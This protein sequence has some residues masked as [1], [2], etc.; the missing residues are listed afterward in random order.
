MNVVWLGLPFGEDVYAARGGRHEIRTLS[1]DEDTDYRFAPDETAADVVARIGKEWP[2]DLFVCWCPELRP[3]PHAVEQ[4][5]VR[6]VAAVSDWNIYYPQLEY[7]LARYDVVLTDRLGSQC[8]ELPGAVPQYVTPLYSQRS[9]VHRN[10]DLDRDIDVLFVGNLNHAIHG[11]RG[12]CLERIAALSDQYAVAIC[13]GIYD[14]DYAR[15]LNRARIVFNHSVRREMNLRCFEALACGALLFVEEDNLEVGDWLRDRE[16][17]VLFRAENLIPLLCHYLDRP[18][19]ADRIA[20]QGHAR[21]AELAAESRLDALFE[22]AAG[23]PRGQGAAAPCLRNRGFAT[24]SEETRAFADVMQYSSSLAPSQRA[25]VTGLLAEMRGRFPNR[26]E[27]LAA[28][29]CA[30]LE[31][32]DSLSTEERK[33]A[34]REVL[35][36]FQQACSQAPESAVMWLNLAHVSRLADAPEAE[37]A[38]LERALEAPDA[39]Y[40]GL[41]IGKPTDP[42]YAQWRRALALREL[43]VEI[44]W[45]AAATRLAALH[46]DR[47]AFD[48]ARAFAQRGLGWFPDN[49]MPYRIWAVAES[50]LG[51]PELAADILERALPTT[52]FDE[53]YRTDLVRALI[54]AGRRD[55]AREVAEESRRLF[56]CCW[57]CEHI[58]REFDQMLKEL[59]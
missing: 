32:L 12:R 15:L 10:M 14:E 48:T 4:C 19:E 34:T 53:A 37:A 23:Q 55:R 54:A 50:R 27:F 9:A 40:G 5:P 36:W 41:L 22:W 2:V 30:A 51:Q 59:R 46:L 38:C 17:V 6:T 24:F 42:Y 21:A 31:G 18:D 56:S 28:S 8:L 29:G 33:P 44:L 20:R 57:A 43:R 11:E 7:N 49:A 16:E 13:G 58:V 3:P 45:A 35:G 39:G 25:Q 26:P 47:E 1:V 52:I